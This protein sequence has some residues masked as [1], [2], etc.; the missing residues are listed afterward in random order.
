MLAWDT[1]ISKP[2]VLHKDYN[3]YMTGSICKCGITVENFLRVLWEL[4]GIIFLKSQEQ[5]KLL[6]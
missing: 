2:G 3:L 5:N 1:D 6:T 4:S